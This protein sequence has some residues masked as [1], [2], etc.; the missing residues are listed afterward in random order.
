[1]HQKILTNLYISIH[2]GC[3]YD[4]EILLAPMDVHFDTENIVQPDLIFIA[5]D[6]LN[7]IR[8]GFVFGVPELLVEILSKSTGKRD[9]TIKKALYERFGVK[10]FWLIDPGYQTVDQ[11]VLEKS[12]YRLAATL[13]EG[14]LIGSPTVPCLSVDLGQIFPEDERD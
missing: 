2:G 10:E 7:I 9:K 14:D 6:N 11:F 12:G 5:K 3:R 1:M 4:G 13:T 8:D